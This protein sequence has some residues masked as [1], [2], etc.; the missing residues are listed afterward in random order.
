MLSG[1]LTAAA[2]SACRRFGA[3]VAGME[4]FRDWARGCG[5]SWRTSDGAGDLVSRPA[6]PLNKGLARFAATVGPLV[7]IG[8]GGANASG[9]LPL[10][11]R[12]CAEARAVF[13]ISLLPDCGPELDRPT[14]A[15]G[16]QGRFDR[17]PDAVCRVAARDGLRLGIA[18]AAGAWLLGKAVFFLETLAVLD[19]VD[20]VMGALVFPV[21]DAGL[22]G[23][24]VL[25]PGLVVAALDGLAFFA[26]ARVL[27]SNGA[28][29]RLAL[30]VFLDMAEQG[31][32]LRRLSW[33]RTR[34]G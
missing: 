17:A 24:F 11:V 34:D 22:L 21:L 12:A 5:M 20:A 27:D 15:D 1:F 25:S 19:L 32:R 4:A 29:E 23:K 26:G 2:N 33:R 6:G 28:L 7:R 30:R 16:L 10:L 9:S 3:R 18:F 8:A 31:L 14:A 13:E